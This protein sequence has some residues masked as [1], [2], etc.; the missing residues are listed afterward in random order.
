MN[1]STQTSTRIKTLI[2]QNYA[3]YQWNQRMDQ[4]PTTIPS[5]VY[6]SFTNPVVSISRHACIMDIKSIVKSYN[7]LICFV[8]WYDHIPLS[9]PTP[10]PKLINGAR[11]KFLIFNADL[12]LLAGESLVNP[13]PMPESS[14][15]GILLASNCASTALLEPKLVLKLAS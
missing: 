14:K 5:H 13:S 7:L 12:V 4:S 3:Q 11:S 15:S 1:A 9:L 8:V 6:P 10:S 2:S